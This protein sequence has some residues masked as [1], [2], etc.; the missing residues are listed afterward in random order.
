MMRAADMRRLDATRLRLLSLF[1]W[2]AK[3]GV[4]ERNELPAHAIASHGRRC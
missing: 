4:L 1:L 3:A 2:R